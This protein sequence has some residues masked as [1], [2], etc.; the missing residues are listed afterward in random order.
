MQSSHYKSIQITSV[1]VEGTGI[2]T[3]YYTLHTEHNHQQ[4]ED[5]E[6]RFSWFEELFSLLAYE[7]LSVCI[8]D[9]LKLKD[10][11]IKWISNPYDPKIQQ[12]QKSL[13]QFLNFVAKHNDL[14]E[15]ESL[16]SF[17]EEPDWN[18]KHQERLFFDRLI[19]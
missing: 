3:H 2:Y 12:R 13:E 18:F 11:S 10:E 9:I 4:I 14:Y 16:K 7:H 6:R 17:L 15:N 5:V 1:R 19:P 8:P